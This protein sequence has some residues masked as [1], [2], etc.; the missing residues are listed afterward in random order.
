M[1]SVYGVQSFIPGYTTSWAY[2]H[3]IQIK[4]DFQV[5]RIKWLFDCKQNLQRRDDDEG[6]DH[7]GNDIDMI[8]KQ[9]SVTRFWEVLRLFNAAKRGKVVYCFIKV[10]TRTGSKLNL[11]ITMSELHFSLNVCMLYMDVTCFSPL[12]F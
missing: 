8:V 9:I 1:L 4:S 6:D 5:N 7:D 10:N 2:K 3:S 12:T 11:R